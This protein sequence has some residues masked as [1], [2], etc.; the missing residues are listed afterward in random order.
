MAD[1]PNDLYGSKNKKE[2]KIGP[3]GEKPKSVAF[4]KCSLDNRFYMPPRISN[5]Q[6]KVFAREVNNI[7]K[8]TPPKRRFDT[9]TG[10]EVTT[11]ALYKPHYVPASG[12]G[13][14]DGKIVLQQDFNRVYNP[15]MDTWFIDTTPRNQDIDHV[16]ALITLPAQ[17]DSTVDA[18]YKDGPFQSYNNVSI[19]HFLTM[20]TVKGVT[21]FDK[22]AAKGRPTSILCDEIY[23]TASFSTHI[24]HEFIISDDLLANAY[25]AYNASM[26]ALNANSLS[27]LMFTMPSPVYPDMVAVPLL[28]R[29]RCYGPWLSTNAQQFNNQSRFYAIPGKVEFIK[30]EDLAPWNYGGYQLLNEAGALQAEFSNSRMLITEKGSFTYEGLPS[31]NSL[32]NFL[33][34]GGPLVTNIDVSVDSS[35][36]VTTTYSMNIYTP[37]FGKLQR[38]KETLISQISRERQRSIDERND[39]IRKGLGKSQKSI[40]YNDLYQRMNST[41][42]TADFASAWSER[43]KMGEDLAYKKVVTVENKTTQGIVKGEVV[44]KTSQVTNE[45]IN[46]VKLVNE[47]N[48]RQPNASELRRSVLNSATE[49]PAYVTGSS[50]RTVQP[51]NTKSN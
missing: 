12:G 31:G 40:N 44:D 28:S 38:Q 45:K 11:M 32:G 27:S 49:K 35:A 13:G 50:P 4:V 36:G 33:V 39:L 3:S 8:L 9:E 34:D 7:H 29:E 21:G 15:Y 19:K 20:D 51:T 6:A 1:F 25:N 48:D 2:S 24:S 23:T 22:P 47:I 46:P 30:Q 17:V 16:Y 18:R 37:R 42:G 26:S 41:K 43:V 14:F 5:V 10:E